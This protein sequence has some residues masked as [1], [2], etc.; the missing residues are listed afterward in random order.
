MATLNIL[1]INDRGWVVRGSI[2]VVSAVSTS[3]TWFDLGNP[4]AIFPFMTRGGGA[5]ILGVS[6][7]GTF[8]LTAQVL[9]SLQD[10]TPSSAPAGASALAWPTLGSTTTPQMFTI[11]Q[12]IR[13]VAFNCSAFTSGSATA[14]VYGVLPK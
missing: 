5:N 12:P 13:W 11:N 1:D 2:G 8:S 10:S 7:E 9:I 4:L 14:W 6:V 3:L